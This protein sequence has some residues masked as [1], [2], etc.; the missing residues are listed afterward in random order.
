M[1]SKIISV[2]LFC[3]IALKS[4]CLC[5]VWNEP[6]T[7][8]GLCDRMHRSFGK[9]LLI[10]SPHLLM[11]LLSSSACPFRALLCFSFTSDI[12]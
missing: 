9:H 8:E 3:S 12:L 4:I 2:T 1:Q 5:Y 7:H 6:F 10:E 11:P